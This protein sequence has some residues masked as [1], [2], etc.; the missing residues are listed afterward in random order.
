MVP[1]IDAGAAAAA[2]AVAGGTD[3]AGLPESM[4]CMGQGVPTAGCAVFKC[5][6][7][8]APPRLLVSRESSRVFVFN[9]GL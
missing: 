5:G 6:P 1:N 7:V 4:W 9:E 2:A 3:L 8:H